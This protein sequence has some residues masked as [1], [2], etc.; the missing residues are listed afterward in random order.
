[1]KI[2]KKK[3]FSTLKSLFKISGISFCTIIWISFWLFKKFYLINII[4]FEYYKHDISN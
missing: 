4:K 3:T 2:K 1:M